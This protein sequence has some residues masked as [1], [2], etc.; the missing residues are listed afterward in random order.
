MD[1]LKHLKQ[2]IVLSAIIVST[3]A[4]PS[5][6]HEA[7]QATSSLPSGWS[8]IGCFS[9][10]TDARTL[11]TAAFTDVTGMT[12]ESCLAFC[13]PA[14]YKYAGVE[15]SREC[16]CDNNIE[17]PGAPIDASACSMPCTGNSGEICGGSNAIN[18]FQSTPAPPLPSGWEAVGCFSDSTDS[19]TLRVASFTDVT[20]MTIE[21]CLEFCT[22]AGYKYAGLEFA[23]ECYCDNVIESP[24][25]PIAAS[26]CS[27]LC[28]GSGV[29]ICG[30]SNALSVFQTTEV[31]PPPPP[32][33]SIKQTAG[34]FNYV[35]CF[36]DA[37]NGVP[38]SLA[39][40][41]MGGDATAETCTAACKTA[42]FALA[43]LEFGGECW[44]DHYMARAN[45]V[46]DSDCNSVCDADHTELCGAGNRLA[47]Y[48][49]T[50]ATQ[51][52]FQN[53]I[54]SSLIT[55]NSQT[56]YDFTFIMSPG[57]AGGSPVP[58]ALIPNG[59][60][61]PIHAGA[62]TEQF[63]QLS[64]RTFVPTTLTPKQPVEFALN[65]G[66]ID[67]DQVTQQFNQPI[68][69]EPG[70]PMQFEATGIAVDDFSGYCAMPNPSIT[71]GSLFGPPVLGVTADGGITGQS[72]IWSSCQSSPGPLDPIFQASA[73]R[74]VNCTSVFLEMPPI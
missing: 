51:L 66:F 22:P 1:R 64:G 72:N 68:Q 17:S 57:P 30:G 19:R 36:T 73:P 38:R 21:S 18:I 42:G 62:T 20:G 10:S 58:L 37:V 61:F 9:D 23:R 11:R 44:C 27:T 74:N 53:C 3:T 39:T 33:A 69:P 24:G 50:T 4:S 63:W 67:P 40:K 5:G 47:V 16:Y 52:S 35:G 28:T 41:V 14:G 59:D 48:Q 29:E 43:G 60:P 13:V 54:P 12:I 49:D 32:P 46:P 8:A 56:P 15:F 25:A 31:T 2:L 34:T 7:R 45:H 26:S 70:S 71:F 65:G 6:V 55:P